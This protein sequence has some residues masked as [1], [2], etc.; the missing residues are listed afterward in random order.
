M[1]APTQQAYPLPA[2]GHDPRFSFELLHSVA[3]VL[4]QHG[5]PPVR[6]GAD[7]LE[8]KAALYG[9]LYDTGDR[10]VTP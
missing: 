2:S 7:L 8:L 9:F 5:Y 4:E 10:A 3:Q 6:A 1:T